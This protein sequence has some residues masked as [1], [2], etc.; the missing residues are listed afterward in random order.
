[1]FLL[2][3]RCIAVNCK[4]S[5]TVSPMVIVTYCFDSLRRIVR[6]IRQM[7]TFAYK[8]EVLSAD[9]HCKQFGPRPGP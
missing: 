5:D 6:F 7:L 1:M 9:Y 2:F 8:A 3:S 4:A